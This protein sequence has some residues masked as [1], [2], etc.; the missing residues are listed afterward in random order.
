M[1]KIIL[2]KSDGNVGGYDTIQAAIDAGASGDCVIL[3]PGTYN[4]NLTINKNLTLESIGD[5]TIAGDST[6]GTI[7][8]AANT[9]VSIKGFPTI[10]N[11]N[12]VDKRI[13]CADAT[14]IIN[15]FY[16]EFSGRIQQLPPATT[17]SGSLAAGKVYF[18][19][20]F[21]AG[22]DFSNV[23]SVISGTINTTGCFFKATGTTPT[24]W[25]NGSTLD[26]SGAPYILA[27]FK[28]TTGQDFGINW[29]YSSTGSVTWSGILSPIKTLISITSQGARQVT[30]SI[31]TNT[32]GITCYNITA[33]PPALV[34]GTAF[35]LNIRMFP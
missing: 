25:S 28:N 26:Y 12:G 17:T 33:D 2:I 31:S 11:S 30:Y 7:A 23:A 5:V 3:Y 20:T 13:V 27:L 32:I 14:A 6:S 4:E 8:I 18:I 22:D 21:N 19:T 16:W 1:K 10:T 34:N 35:M 15:D 9:T 24:N 29:S